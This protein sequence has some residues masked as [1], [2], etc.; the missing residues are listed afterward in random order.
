ML[1][2]AELN[3]FI[4]KIKKRLMDAGITQGELAARNLYVSQC[5]ISGVLN[6]VDPMGASLRWRDLIPRVIYSIPG[7]LIFNVIY[8]RSLSLLQKVIHFESHCSW[9]VRPIVHIRHNQRP[10][11]E[12]KKN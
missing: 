7:T 9:K 8:C 11:M 12:K 1:N 5:A 2:A 10:Y 4:G 3:E 6:S